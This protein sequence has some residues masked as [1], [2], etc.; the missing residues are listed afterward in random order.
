ML[1]W[2]DQMVRTPNPFVERMTFFLHRHFANSRMTVSPPQLLVTQNALFRSYADFSA[3]PTADF[4]SLVNDVSIDPSML[5]YLTGESN[6]AGAPNENY[7]RELME[8]FTLGPINDAGM[9]NYSEDDVQ[10][11]AKALT[12]W[13]INDADPNEVSAYFTTSRWYIGP[14]F[15]LGTF[16]NWKTPDVVSL[17]LSQPNHPIFF[18]RKLWGEFIPTP[19]RR[20]DA[21]RRSRRATSRAACSSSRC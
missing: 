11:L 8:L 20:A 12:G 6:V 14:K 4:K 18:V 7:A 16:G 21:R 19:T 1:S 5:R 2:V 10:S 3:N 15:A 17:V 9:P 13:Q